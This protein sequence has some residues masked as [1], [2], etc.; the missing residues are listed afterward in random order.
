MHSTPQETNTQQKNPHQNDAERPNRA[1]QIIA[2]GGEPVLPGVGETA[3]LLRY[4]QD[5]GLVGM[6][7]MGPVRLSALEVMAWQ[8]GSGLALTPWEFS[9]LR[10]MSAHYLSSVQAGTK[11]ECP[12]PFGDSVN[13]FNRDLVQKK[14]VSQFKAFILSTSGSKG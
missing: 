3:Y 1:E 4:W 2:R 8:Q 5:L 10:E 14:V 13:Q 9:V 12:P 11:V 6:G 7:A